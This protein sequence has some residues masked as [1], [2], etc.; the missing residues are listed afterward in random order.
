M[1]K[2]QPNEGKK[3]GFKNDTL[4]MVQR[5][6]RK[7]TTNFDCDMNETINGLF[8]LRFFKRST[9]NEL[10]KTKRKNATKKKKKKIKE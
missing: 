10:Q 8:P 2:K 1:R 4:K 9:T 3:Y 5:S 6:G 7:N